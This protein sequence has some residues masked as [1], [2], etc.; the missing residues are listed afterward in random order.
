MSLY[1]VFALT[2][3]IFDVLTS[4]VL[5]FC[6]VPVWELLEKYV[7]L[8]WPPSS[9]TSS[10]SVFEWSWLT[11]SMR[12]SLVFFAVAVFVEKLLH[13]PWDWYLTFVIEERH[14]FNKTTPRT[15]ILDAVKTLL[16]SWLIGIPV[17]TIVLLCFEWGPYF[18]LYIYGVVTLVTLF[19]LFTYHSL[20][21]PCFNTFKPLDP[22]PLR[23]ALSALAR[24]VHFPLTEI[25][26]VD[27]STR[28]A[29]SN[30][31]FYGFFRAKRIVL[32]DT[33]VQRL[34]VRDIE[35]VIAHELG[36]YAHH[37]FLLQLLAHQAEIFI[38]IWLFSHL[39]HNVTLYQ[40]FGFSHSS[41]LPIPF[42]GLILFTIFYTPL[43]HLSTFLTHL[44][45][46]HMEYQAD[47]YAVQLGYD[48]RSIS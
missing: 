6:L 17:L 4:I 5:C 27:G 39:V 31:Y 45:S 35:A 44:W 12:V 34:S 10:S 23:D 16:L 42:V 26:I 21:A 24:R 15:F 19:F 13:L 48:L 30:A 11:L 33:L 37:H 40:S 28:S 22:G 38:F 29:H 41:T 25:Y 14:G 3:N 7:N 46:R 47:R 8:V 43:S 36:H 32:Y 18:Y 20:I 9:S 1:S 2:S